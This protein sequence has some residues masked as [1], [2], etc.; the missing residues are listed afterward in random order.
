MKKYYFV[1]C[2]LFFST[3]AFSQKH[4]KFG[5]F[6][7]PKISWISPESRNV[8]S[9]GTFFGFGGG[10]EIDR[11][12]AKNYAFSTGI[13]LGSQGGKLSF[14]NLQTLKVYDEIDTLPAGTT[15]KYKLQY[16]TVPLGLKLKSNQ[17]GYS[18]FF[19]NV[20]FTSQINVKAKGTT[21]NTGTYRGL[22][23]DA[24]KDEINWINLGYHFGGGVEYA[25]GEDTSLLVGL[26]YQN[27]FLDITKSSPRT[28]SRVISL[29]VGIMF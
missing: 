16:I 24:I 7:D 17:I 11:F 12:F 14:D 26:Q 21:E 29:R 28:L 13:S 6:V 9:D 8:S 1:A 10:L 20:G 3:F 15:F 19:V 18:T 22:E 5:V 2:L 25:L 27:G 4:T 23:D